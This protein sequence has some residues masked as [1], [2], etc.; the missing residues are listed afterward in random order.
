MEL[1]VVKILLL[2]AAVWIVILL[3]RRYQRSLAQ[4]D[5]TVKPVEN[6]VKC[7]HCAV[8]LPRGEAIYTQGDFYCTVEHQRLG[9]K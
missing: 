1:C 2:I 3:V 4:P 8:N 6:M 5:A 9:K 7:A